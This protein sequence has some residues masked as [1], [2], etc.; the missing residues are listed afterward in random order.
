MHGRLPEREAAKITGEA[1]LVEN[2][3]QSKINRV[4]AS[5]PEPGEEEYR[6]YGADD[7]S[8]G[9]SEVRNPPTLSRT[10]RIILT[11]GYYWKDVITQYERWL[12]K[13]H[14]IP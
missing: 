13:I 11:T 6:Y 7:N 2:V 12:H 9:T 10:S 5:P 3:G 4:W 8:G 14:R 1:L